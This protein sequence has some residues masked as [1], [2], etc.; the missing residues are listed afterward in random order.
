MKNIKK[1]V[2]ALMT[3]FL[4]FAGAAGLSS[5]E[6]DL[7][8]PPVIEPE[9]G[10][11]TGAWDKPLT[12]NQVLLGTSNPAL[13]QDWVT[14]YIVGWVNSGFGTVLNARTATFTVPADLSSNLLLAMDSLETDW[15][16][17]IPVKLISGNAR[18]S[19]NLQDNPGNLHKMVTVRG[20]TGEKYFGIYGVRDV[21]MFTWDDEGLEGYDVPPVPN[22]TPGE[23]VFKALLETE[24]KMP[25][26]WTIMNDS[27]PPSDS[28]VNIW[29]WDQYRGAGYL[30]AS[31]KNKKYCLSYFI[32]PEI[33][34]SKYR[35]ASLNFMHAAKFQTTLRSLCGVSVREAGTGTWTDIPVIKWPEAD[36]WTFV[37][38]GA[39]DIT[40]FAGKKVEIAFR[41]SSSSEGADTWEIRNLIVSGVRN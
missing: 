19:L 37:N 6:G 3:V 32:S 31:Y 21:S 25:D 40:N 28:N 34:L 18:N 26:G 23:T 24:Q 27:I 5:C 30:K 10:V 2:S 33:D 14:G 11:G 38:S 4:A 41:Y 20:T 36:S 13:D 29:S 16:K 12:V 35:R 7:A 39:L 15:E 1:S 8:Q 9:G 17:C 22:P